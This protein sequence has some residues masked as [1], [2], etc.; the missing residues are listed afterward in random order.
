MQFSNTLAALALTSLAQYVVA[1]SESF[2]LLV[3]RSGSKYQYSSITNKDDKFTVG[4]DTTSYIEG[5]ITDSGDFKLTDG[6]YAKVNSDGTI[7]VADEGSSPFSIKNGY[8]AYEG[9]QAFSVDSSSGLLAGSAGDSIALRA[10]L[11]SGSVASDFTPSGSSDSS[12]S[13]SN[14]SNTSTSTATVITQTANG[15]AG[16][17]SAG[18]GAGL[19]A[20]AAMFLM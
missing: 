3:I 20:A 11:K 16:I 17:A 10:T 12:S 8:F 13:K 14:S 15:A 18:V 19:A 7:S 5:V 1:D 2:G 4:G 9:S 6:K